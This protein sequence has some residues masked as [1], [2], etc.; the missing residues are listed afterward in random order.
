[1]Q[2]AHLH[3]NSQTRSKS[4]QAPRWVFLA[5]P[6]NSRRRCCAYISSPGVCRSFWMAGIGA[7][8][9]HAPSV[10]RLCR[11][12]HPQLGLGFKATVE[13]RN[14]RVW[15][16]LLTAFRSPTPTFP[17]WDQAHSE[18]SL[19][20]QGNGTRQKA[21]Q[22]RLEPKSQL[23]TGK[24]KKR[25]PWKRCQQQGVTACFSTIAAAHLCCSTASVPTF[26]LQ[27][28]HVVSW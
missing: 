18:C 21:L 25:A 28:A 13:G 26:C 19:L 14:V 4:P 24:K 17:G 7:E 23:N 11:D 20:V 8:L 16:F 12:E 22:E 10:F 3:V 1:M 5:C 15:F 6:K 2:A 27:A 9:K